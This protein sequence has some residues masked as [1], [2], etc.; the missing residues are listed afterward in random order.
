MPQ[1]KVEL[2]RTRRA[3]PRGEG[4]EGSSQHTTGVTERGMDHADS[5]WDWWPQWW[6]YIPFPG[7]VTKAVVAASEA[8]NQGAA[9][10]GAVCLADTVVASYTFNSMA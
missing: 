8:Q 6:Y 7:M 9:G 1:I 2:N 4:Q 10:L 3:L 5:L